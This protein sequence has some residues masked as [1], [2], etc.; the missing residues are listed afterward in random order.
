VEQK[1]KQAAD[2]HHSDNSWNTVSPTEE[3]R[4]CM[5]IFTSFHDVD[6]VAGIT[7]C[8]NEQIAVGMN[9]LPNFIK[10]LF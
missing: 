4:F 5:M 1:A 3:R 9:L 6:S 8:G 7:L 2:A 10:L